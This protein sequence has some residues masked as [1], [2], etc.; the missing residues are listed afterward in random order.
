MEINK[1]N[2]LN[3]DPFSRQDHDVIEVN[4]NLLVA[5]GGRTNDRLVLC[6]VV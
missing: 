3:S 5:V 2:L 6:L 4:D 1:W